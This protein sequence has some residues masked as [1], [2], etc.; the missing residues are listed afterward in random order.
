M[1]APR[2]PGD[3]VV[4]IAAISKSL[5]SPPMIVFIPRRRRW[6]IAGAGHR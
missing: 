6:C 1:S 5:P 2:P 4:A 3:D